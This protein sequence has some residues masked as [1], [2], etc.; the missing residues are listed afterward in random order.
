MVLVTG[1]LIISRFMMERKVRRKSRKGGKKK[2]WS[3]LKISEKRLNSFQIGQI[4][5]AFSEKSTKFKDTP[6]KNKMHFQVKYE[7][8][9]KIKSYV[10]CW[11][12]NLPW[13]CVWFVLSYWINFRAYITIPIFLFNSLPSCFITTY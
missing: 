9:M 10:S 2:E 4:W 5:S 1:F 6:L 8:T 3:E 11:V 12:S 7:K 13:K